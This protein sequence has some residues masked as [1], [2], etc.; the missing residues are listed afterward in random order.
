MNIAIIMCGYYKIP[1]HTWIG[2]MAHHLRTTVLSVGF[3]SASRAALGLT[4]TVICF[5]S[6]EVIKHVT[7]R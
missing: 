6:N 3:W 7:N 1:Q 4:L 5:S 2:I